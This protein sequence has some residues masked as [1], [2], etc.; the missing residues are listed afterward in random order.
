MDGEASREEAYGWWRRKDRSPASNTDGGGGEGYGYTYEGIYEGLGRVTEALQDDGPFDGVVGFSQGGAAAGMVA[1]MLEPGR[2]EAF[3]AREKEGGMAWPD[4][5]SKSEEAE[6]E[7][8][9]IHPPLKFAASY[10]GFAPQPVPA[11]YRAFYEP[12][13]A[14]PMLH[15]LGEV[16]TVVEESRSLA[17][18]DV[19]VDARVTRHPGGHFLPASSR[20]CVAALVALIKETM[21]WHETGSARAA[22]GGP[23]GK[24]EPRVEAMDVPF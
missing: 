13:I 11:L 2:R 14:T 17:L 15:F 3:N 8:A 21:G 24:G 22:N 1:A 5:F 18:V 9:L 4:S 7:A 23:G 10:S 19:C 6:A 12:K 20:E 16:D